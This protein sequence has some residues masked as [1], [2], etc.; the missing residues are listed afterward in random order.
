[1]L[2]TPAGIAENPKPWFF[3]ILRTF[4][5]VKVRGLFVEVV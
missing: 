4:P 1:M 5:W 3:L 2:A